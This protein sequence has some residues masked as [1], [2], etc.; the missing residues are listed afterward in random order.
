MCNRWLI[1]QK[2]CSN[3]YYI[4]YV[5]SIPIRISFGKICTAPCLSAFDSSVFS[6]WLPLLPSPAGIYSLD[7]FVRFAD[8]EIRKMQVSKPW[9]SIFRLFIFAQ[10]SVL[11]CFE[12]T[13]CVS[14]KMGVSCTHFKIGQPI[15]DYDI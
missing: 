13:Y 7:I 3:E 12:N 9:L 14:Y 1:S 4:E 10:L 11:E 8:D 15:P 2:H 6:R 5:F